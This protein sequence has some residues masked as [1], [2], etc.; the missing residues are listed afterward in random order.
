MAKRERAGADSG[1]DAGLKTINSIAF[2]EQFKGITNP[3]TGEIVKILKD[4]RYY[5]FPG[6]TDVYKILD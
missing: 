1:R 4:Q 5:I 2:N 6:E 3:K